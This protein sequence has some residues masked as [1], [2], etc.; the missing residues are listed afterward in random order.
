MRIN[1]SVSDGNILY[2]SLG[3]P[4]ILFGPH[5]IAFHTENE[6]VKRS[7]LTVYM[8]ELYAYILAEYEDCPS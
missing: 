3:T 1:Q 5:G 4:T 8:E 7:S 2:N 6:Y